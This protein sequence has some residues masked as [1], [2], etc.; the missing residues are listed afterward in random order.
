MVYH[1]V[2]KVLK[3]EILEKV[4]TMDYWVRPKSRFTIDFLPSEFVVIFTIC[5]SIIASLW[6]IIETQGLI[7]FQ[8]SIASYAFHCLA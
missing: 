1:L 2:S 5:V 8:V 3:S 6:K 4:R 7:A